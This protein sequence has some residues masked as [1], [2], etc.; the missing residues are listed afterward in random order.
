MT[1]G[2]APVPPRALSWTALYPWYVTGILALTHMVSLVDRHL[3]GVALVD[4]KQELRLTD[5]QLGLLYGTGFAVIYALVSLPLGRMADRVNRKN[6]IAA[7][8]IC[9]TAATAVTAFSNSFGTMFGLRMVVGIGE[10]CLVPAGMSLLTAL[11]PRPLLARAT[12]VFTTGGGQGRTVALLV[13]GPLLTYLAAVGG[14]NVLGET[15]SPWRGLFLLASLPGLLLVPLL[16]MLREPGRAHGGPDRKQE[17]LRAVLGVLRER[18]AAY[19]H[20]FG[21]FTMAATVIWVLSA[22][23]LSVFV[24]EHGLSAGQ[25]GAILGTVALVTGPIGNILGGWLLDRMTVRGVRGAPPLI[26][27]VTLLCT[28]P[29]ILLFSLSKDLVFAVAGY[30]SLQFIMTFCNAP[31]WVGVQLLTPPAHRGLA[32]ALFVATYTTLSIGVG[33]VVVGVL[34]DHVFKGGSALG[35]SVMTTLLVLV[36]I[37]G[38]LSLAG[39]SHFGRAAETAE[40]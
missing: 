2:V 15:L 22:W 17:S 18:F 29:S 36:V 14:L 7:G 40:K 23:A 6:L 11:M 21:G 33:P 34:S 19:A 27:G 30:A 16:L 13:G 3:L 24:R 9:W 32:M 39:R 25:A 26:I 37:G 8:L 31:G 20:H 35:L 5:T 28:V 10:A 12:A 38:L 1:N 4:V